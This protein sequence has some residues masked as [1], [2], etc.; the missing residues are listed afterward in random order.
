MV[1]PVGRHDLVIDDE[2]L[3]VLLFGFQTLLHSPNGK[4]QIMAC[5]SKGIPCFRPLSRRLGLAVFSYNARSK[6]W[7]FVPM[8]EPQAAERE[9]VQF[10]RSFLPDCL[11]DQPVQFSGVDRRDGSLLIARNIN[12][13]HAVDPRSLT[14]ACVTMTASR[15]KTQ[16]PSQ[17][18]PT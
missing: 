17:P 10:A 5:A 9:T 18:M 4:G 7:S 3:N 12:F 13:S 16:N 15:L 2:E 6:E 1:K 14:E 8:W 11:V